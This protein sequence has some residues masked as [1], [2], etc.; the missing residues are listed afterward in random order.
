MIL[1]FFTR[2]APQKQSYFALELPH[3][4]WVFGLDLALA[5]DIDAV[6]Y[7]FFKHVSDQLMKPNHRGLIFV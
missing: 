6:Q 1:F 7:A 4:W 5:N 3:G 2:H